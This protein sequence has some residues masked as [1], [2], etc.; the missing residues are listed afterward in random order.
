MGPEPQLA[1]ALVITTSVLIIAC[2]CA[3]GLAT[4]MSIMVGVGRAA[5]LGVLYKNGDAIERAGKITTLVLD[6]TGTI[7]QGK[8][9]VSQVHFVEAENTEL[10]MN[11]LAIIASIEAVSEHPLAEAIVSYLQQQYAVTQFEIENF[12]AT[13]GKGVS[14][15]C[16]GKQVLIGNLTWLKTNGVEL[17]NNSVPELIHQQANTLVYVAVNQKLHSVFCIEDKIRDDSLTSIQTLQQQ[18]IDIVMLTGD[19]QAVA[20]KVAK[21]L[22]INQVYA[23]LSPVDKRDIIAQIKHQQPQSIIAMVG[24]GIND[25]PALA[26]ADIGLA[27]G[28][29]TDIAMQSADIV[30]MHGSLSTVIDAI[31]VSQATYTNIK[32]NLFAAFAYNSAAIP[33]AAGVLYP[34]LG[35]ILNPMIAGLAMALSSVTVVLNANRLRA[36]KLD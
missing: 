27:M 13:V 4:P 16:Q 25:A 20:N 34:S 28:Q 36:K 31:A 18:G 12:N 32:Q 7:T 10:D 5:K 8:P 21:S 1:Y 14:A 3:L 35:F 26:A 15:Q 29:G 9:Q 24:D 22:G 30:L 19:N 11:D 23:E 17:D 6:K 2:P 33:I